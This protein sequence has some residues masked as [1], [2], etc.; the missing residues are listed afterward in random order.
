ME[1]WQPLGKK[2]RTACMRLKS[3]AKDTE[4]HFRNA[5]SFLAKCQIIGP[6]VEKGVLRGSV[7]PWEIGALDTHG[8]TIVEDFHDTLEAI[9]VW[10]YYTKI[11]K[12]FAYKPNIQMGW[13][14]ITANFPRF[15]PP[16][17]EDEGLYD[18][19]WLALSGSIYEKVFADKSY[20][21]WI[22]IAGDRLACYI[23]S[24]RSIRGR[25]YYD[26]WWMAA[27]LASAAQ[28]LEHR[29]WLKVAQKFV[30]QKVIEE[31][32]P[33]SN[34]E[35]EPR[36]KGLG[37]HDFFSSNANK[38]LALLSSFPS[39]ALA[40]EIV[41]NKFLPAT[42]KSFV[43]RHADENAWNANLAT[44]LG[45]SYLLTGEEEFLCRY[46]SIMDELKKRDSQ[47]SSALPRSEGYPIKE[48]WV[49][50]FY[51]YAYASATA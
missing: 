39:E 17:K 23:S 26:P 4:R 42:A 1:S 45:K 6:Y 29:E 16:S 14:Y 3:H 33:F 18:C 10:S 40:T 2:Q 34:V 22:E 50:S 49:T 35:K 20:R 41:V 51:A 36:H 11:S 9:W 31:Q 27:C 37:G 25:E 5:A 30:R 32:T 28:F 47:N 46:F 7:C 12:N 38:A 24:I 8:F 21:K 44:V 15:V 43:K 48:S 19:S 13:E